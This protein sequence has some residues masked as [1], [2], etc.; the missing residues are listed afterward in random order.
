MSVLSESQ[1]GDELICIGEFSGSP[2]D[3]VRTWETLRTFRIGE[4]VRYVGYYQ[5]QNIKDNP[6]CWMVIFDAADGQRYAATQ[7]FFVTEE[8]WQRLKKFFV[9]RLLKEPARP[10]TP[11]PR[12][13]TPSS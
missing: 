11:S 10:R 2:K 5:D 3:T 4:R 7:T 9:K 12:T 6:I 13:H 8:C 1:A